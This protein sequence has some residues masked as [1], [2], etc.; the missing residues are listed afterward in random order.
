[1]SQNGQT[2]FRALCIKGFRLSYEFQDLRS[3]QRCSVK[4]VVL[5]NIPKFTEIFCCLRACN[6]I[7]NRLQH[8]CFHVKHAKFLRTSTLKKFYD[9]LLLYEHPMDIMSCVVRRSTTIY[10]RRIDVYSGHPL[11]YYCLWCPL[12][13]HTYINKPAAFSCTFV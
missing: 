4:K 13:G 11:I 2:H 3:T 7:K 9:R 12:K 5:K 10:W 8:K 6:F 1:M